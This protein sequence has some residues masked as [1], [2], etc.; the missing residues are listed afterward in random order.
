[1]KSP[2]DFQSI[3]KPATD[4]ARQ[5]GIR[6]NEERSGNEKPKETAETARHKD[7]NGNTARE[8]PVNAALESEP[9][10]EYTWRD[11]K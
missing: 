9:A 10:P 3:P 4:Q 8:P 1:M 5:A 2:K 11:G 6:L 7:G